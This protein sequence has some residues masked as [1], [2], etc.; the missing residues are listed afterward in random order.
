M[1]SFSFH[2]LLPKGNSIRQVDNRGYHKSKCFPTPWVVFMFKGES[3]QIISLIN[4]ALECPGLE[5]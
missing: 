4:L 3:D 5:G 1:L 2:S